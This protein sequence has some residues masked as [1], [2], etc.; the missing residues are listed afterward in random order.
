[1]LQFFVYFQRI[2]AISCLC[3]NCFVVPSATWMLY[4]GQAWV[5]TAQQPA[6]FFTFQLSFYQC[7]SYPSLFRGWR[8][9]KLRLFISVNPPHF[10]CTITF[11]H[12]KYHKTLPTWTVNMLQ[13]QDE[14]S[15]SDVQAMD[16]GDQIIE[17]YDIDDEPVTSL[18]FS[19]PSTT[20]YTVTSYTT[21]SIQ[22]VKRAVS[23][24]TAQQCMMTGFCWSSTL[25]S[26]CNNNSN[27]CCSRIVDCWHL[28]LVGKIAAAQC[29]CYLWCTFLNWYLL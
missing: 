1:M 8:A 18:I 12:L 22:V 26:F 11:L 21:T 4:R 20:F 5:S 2:G 6:W 15:D 14:F 9:D 10:G 29:L 3:C 23:S 13:G 7:S 16:I 17:A 19:F 28:W 24:F 27:L 25:S